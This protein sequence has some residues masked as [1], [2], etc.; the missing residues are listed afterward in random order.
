[1][2][3]AACGNALGSAARYC[4]ECGAPSPVRVD[5]PHLVGAW[6]A[7]GRVAQ[8]PLVVTD[9]DVLPASSWSPRPRPL[10]GNEWPPPRREVGHGLRLSTLLPLSSWW[11]DGGWRRG[12]TG[13][14]AGFAV[15]PFILLNLTSDD[16][17]M[18]RAAWGFALYFGLAWLL[19]IH[20]LIRPEPQNRWLLARVV[21][22]TAVAGGFIAV[23]LEEWMGAGDDGVFS[24]IF[25]VGFP[26]ELVKAMPVMLFLF[27]GGRLWTP[28]TY[29]F[30]G[31]VSGLTF[32]VAEAALYAV[33]YDDLADSFGGSAVTISIW[34]L[35]S[36]GMFHACLAAISCFFVGLAHWHRDRAWPLLLFGISLAATLHGIYNASSSQFFGA[37]AA[38]AVVFL[39]LGY[40]RSGDS[41]A[42]LLQ[43]SP[44]VES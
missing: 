33:L 32:G 30:V 8:P 15:A 28:R 27:L 44:E 1:V 39:F 34:R 18:T 24:M 23:A 10:P 12:P 3:C 38:A 29:M 43:K 2:Y 31:V 17:D 40:V 22:F 5:A 9:V 25:K 37:V 14:F 20:A 16:D 7:P 26:E 6:A 19:A 41:I 13:V 42:V 11:R 36:G 21:A 35:L 4:T